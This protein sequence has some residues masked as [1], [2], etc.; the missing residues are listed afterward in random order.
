MFRF[1]V[2]YLN[3]NRHSFLHAFGGT[4]F[5]FYRTLFY[6]EMVPI[7]LQSSEYLIILISLQGN[8]QQT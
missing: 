8:Q 5:T 4:L 1:Y 3:L 7:Q 6:L 2:G